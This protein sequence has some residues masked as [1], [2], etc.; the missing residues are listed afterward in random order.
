[1]LTTERHIFFFTQARPRLV[2]ELKCHHQNVNQNLN[3][4]ERVVILKQD[5]WRKV[6]DLR[7][8]PIH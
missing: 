5:L 7:M 4:K 1:M 3:Y 8:M 2:R 6:L